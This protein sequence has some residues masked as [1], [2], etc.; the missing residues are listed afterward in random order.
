MRY[1]AEIDGL[2]ALAVIPVILFHAGVSG[3]SGGF[4][5]VDIFFVISGFLITGILVDDLE[6]GK[7][8]LAYF[9]ERRIR[10]I[11]P[12]LFAVMVVCMP[13]AWWWLL[14]DQLLEFS[15]SIVATLVFVSNMF[16][17]AK[18]GYFETAAEEKPLLHTWS[19]AVEEQF[20][21]F[22]PIITLYLWKYRK[23]SLLHSFVFLGIISF[24]LCEIGWRE[25]ASANFYLAPARGWELLS[26][27]VAALISRGKPASGSNILSF[28]GLIAVVCAVFFYDRSTPFPSY[29]ALVP[30]LG[31][32][33]VL[34]YGI[35]GTLVAALLSR[36]PFVMIGLIS[37][38]AYLWHQPLFAFQRVR[39]L[40]AP[41]EITM[42][43]LSLLSLVLAYLSWRFIE[44]PFRKRELISREKV[45][46]ILALSAGI[47]LVGGFV[48][49]IYG[50]SPG[51]YFDWK[52][53]SECV[54]RNGF[55]DETHSARISKKCLQENGKNFILIGDSHA[56]SVSK[57]LREVIENHS[58][59]LV[60]LLRDACLPVPQTSRK[61][62]QRA[63][64]KDKS[65]YWEFLSRTPATV[66]FAARWRLNLLGKRF[67]NGEGGIESG[68]SGQ[69]YV[70]GDEN[71]TLVNHLIEQIGELSKRRDVIVFS[72]I[73]E[74]GWHVPHRLQRIEKYGD[75]E[76]LPITTSYEVYRNEN[77]QI[78]EMLEQLE[79]LDR[80]SVF[81]PEALVCDTPMKGRCLNTKEGVSLYL[82]D[83]HPSPTYAALMAMEFERH[84]L[85][86]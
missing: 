42:L 30:V 51:L 43:G 12:A 77:K 41:D 64:V 17:W 27:A 10:R 5:G 39:S 59:G 29:Y 11:L 46:S 34:L 81:R 1:R 74:A 45:F 55:N 48:G 72:Q 7:F 83:D 4:V 58:G 19:L 70:I 57:E 76:L 71:T 25:A 22:F 73:P 49:S 8:S 13:L 16:F 61:P 75:T 78:L 38:S 47:L 82:D 26:G 3:F 67:N 86:E 14:P 24:I 23:F 66:V 9:Y 18:S 69:N 84:Y 68:A 65:E 28:I 62:F 36:K 40:H 44:A 53:A 60:T 54:V 6:C 33:L 15:E 85:Q 80:V 37:Y 35:R 32:V 21:I 56:E 79:L 63:C 2:R 50:S 52:D 31:T 20:Y